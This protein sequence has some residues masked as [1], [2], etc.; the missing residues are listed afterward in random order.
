MSVNNSTIV[1]CINRHYETL[2]KMGYIDLSDI[3]V[4]PNAGWSD[5][6]LHVDA[7][8]A[9]GRSEK[10]IDLLR[11]IP[12]L[13]ENE[14]ADSVEIYPET[15]QLRYLRDGR[16]FGTATEE[17]FSNTSMLDLGFAPFDGPV[18]ADMISL[19]H[20][21]EGVWWVIDTNENVIYPYGTEFDSEHQ[22]PEDQPWRA[23]EPED[24]LSYFNRINHQLDNL[25]VVP[26]P[27]S[28]KWDSRVVDAQTEEGQL[29]SRLYREFG[30]HSG[31]GFR[32]EEFRQAVEQ[33]RAPLLDAALGHDSDD[34][35]EEMAG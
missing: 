32:K 34:E 28:G 3:S 19:T 2:L 35:D 31:G 4:P 27:R 30:W 15:F 14:T 22:A 26:A 17:E 11:L 16:W 20:A 23:V 9:M 7:L 29:V 8:R 25:E 10:V 24:V 18:P 6:Q 13:R 5:E 21:D 33:Q 1:S 12:Y